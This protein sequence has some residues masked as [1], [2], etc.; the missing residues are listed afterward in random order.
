VSNPRVSIHEAPLCSTAY[1]IN[2]PQIPSPNPGQTTIAG[3]QEERPTH[4]RLKKLKKEA[5]LKVET[6][7]PSYDECMEKGI[8]VD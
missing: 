1:I 3:E 2:V 4:I 6:P 5:K 7:P 8:I